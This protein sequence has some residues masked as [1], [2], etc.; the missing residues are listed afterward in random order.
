MYSFLSLDVKGSGRRG[1]LT[2]LDHPALP[3]D[4]KRVFWIQGVEDGQVRGE[5]FHLHGHEL[6]V[7]LRGSLTI[8]LDNGK[9][10]ATIVL[11]SKDNKV[12][13]LQPRTYIRMHN[14]SPDALLLVGCSHA[15]DDDPVS[16]ELD[17]L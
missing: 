13:W 12:L 2:V 16:H 14:F 15:F 1:C 6:L 10:K 5:H 4:L 7:P 3:F 11:N 8:D 9:T 17:E